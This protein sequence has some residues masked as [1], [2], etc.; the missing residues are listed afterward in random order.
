[1]GKPEKATPYLL[2]AVD[3][4]VE[5]NGMTAQEIVNSLQARWSRLQEEA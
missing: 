1:M 3:P 4:V 2:K 5:A